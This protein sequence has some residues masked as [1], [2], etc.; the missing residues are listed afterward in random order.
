[1]LVSICTILSQECQ[2]IQVFRLMFTYLLYF[3][4]ESRRNKVNNDLIVT[5]TLIVGILNKVG[6]NHLTPI[7]RLG[8]R[9]RRGRL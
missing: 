9:C 4:D 3:I 2:N 5:Y 8:H 6:I 1:M 7:W